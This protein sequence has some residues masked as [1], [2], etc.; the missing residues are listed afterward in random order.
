MIE[1]NNK[2]SY[3]LPGS[4]II[5][6]VLIAGALF[7]SGSQPASRQAAQVGAGVAGGKDAVQPPSANENIK[8]VKAVSSGDH[9][10][11]NSKAKVKIVEFSDVEC[12][13]C[14]NFT[15]TMKQVIS[16]Y[17]GQVAWVYRHY[18][19]PFHAS[20]KKGAEAVECAAELGGNEKFWQY[21]DKLAGEEQLSIEVFAKTAE[22]I[23]L[24]K[25]KFESCLES[26]KK[27]SRVTAD[28]EDGSR[29]GCQGTPYS[30]VVVDGKPVSTIEGAY[31]IEEVKK[32][33]DAAIGK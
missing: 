21:L 26:G 27:A 28:M 15:G 11:G 33:I 22:E 5:A 23:G 18:P 7:F 12:S 24:D 19:L 10:F 20:A 1:H 8:N 4:I 32:I 31:P 30:I 14:K 17:N 6:G 25:A 16:D 13:Y 2:N 29:S 9:L 3:F